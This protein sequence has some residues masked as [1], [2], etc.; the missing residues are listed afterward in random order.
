MYPINLTPSDS[1]NIFNEDD[2]N[3]WKHEQASAEIAFATKIKSIIMSSD[4]PNKFEEHE[5]SIKYAEVMAARHEVEFL[6]NTESKD[7]LLELFI[8]EY[9]LEEHL[10]QSHVNTNLVLTAAEFYF[11]KASIDKSRKYA[12]KV[13]NKFGSLTINVLYGLVAQIAKHYIHKL[14]EEQEYKT[15]TIDA[16]LDYYFNAR[17]ILSNE[18]MPFNFIFCPKNACSSIK[19]SLAC[20][21]AQTD[22]EMTKVDPHGAANFYLH[23]NIDFRKEFIILTR[24]PYLRFLSAF[25]SK[26]SPGNTSKV[27]LRICEKYNFDNSSSISMEK[28][29]DA[30]LQVEPNLI[31]GHFRPQHKIF[32]SSIITPSKI[33]TLENIKEYKIFAKGKGVGNSEYLSYA[34]NDYAPLPEELSKSTISKIYKLYEK[35][36]ILYGYSS[37]PSK[38]TRAQLNSNNQY[39]LDLLS[40]RMEEN[41]PSVASLKQKLFNNPYLRSRNYSIE[42]IINNLD[43]LK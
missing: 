32:C 27:F 36:F 42:N 22:K 17:F 30:F 5:K 43:E 4:L 41:N 15:R 1:Q 37:N 39:S 24:N 23:E 33:F 20:T 12:R 19:F 14:P 35:D 21:Y 9:Y 25:R 8:A 29:L 28:L 40:N 16:S 11:R 6:R 31:D 18:K 2:L 3:I 13:F 7:N 10:S 38:R 26:I 34:D